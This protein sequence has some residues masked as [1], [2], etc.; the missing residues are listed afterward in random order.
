MSADHGPRPQATRGLVVLSFAGLAY[1]LGQ[2][3][4]IP[5]LG[6]LKADLGTDSS[7]VAW[8]L[9][10]YLIS[11]AV[12][13]PVFGRLGDMFGK[14]RML[15]ASLSL[16]A[17]G[18]VVS[19]LGTSLEVVVAGRVL[20]GVGGGIFPLAFGIIRDEFPPDRVGPSIGLL[21]ATLGIGGGLGLVIG[22]LVVDHASYHWIFWMSA[23]LA[24]AAGAAIATLVP[25]SPVRRP[26]RVDVRGAFVLGLGLTLPMIAIARANAWGWGSTRVVALLA[27]GI[28]ILV[29]WVALQR[30]TAEPMV[31]V[32]SLGQ[33][34]V[35]LTNLATLLVGLG[36][37]GS[38]LLIPQL[39]EAPE[40][41]GYGSAVSATTAGLVMLPGSLVILLFGPV[42]GTL[43][44]RL[45]NKVPLA[46]GAL[47][48]SLGLFLL[49]AWHGSLPVIALFNVVISIGV[50]LAYAAMPNLIVANV[51][52]HQTGEATGF[53][54]VVRSIGSSLGA[55]VSAAILAGSV[56]AT[57]GLPS[58]HGY[59]WAFVANGLVALAALAVALAIPGHARGGD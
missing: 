27:A 2:T 54:A 25:E 4:L 20:Q 43:G 7:G 58:D 19:A 11:A 42:S 33:R 45:G 55:Q 29:G 6:T 49:G 59:T 31:D 48:T 22:G 18:C 41:T 30:A 15:V 51:P 36:M 23:A 32:R 46:L 47:V 56:L 9:T 12:F 24:A 35:L 17:A 37:F 39:V 16:F 10:G 14:R 13:T 38:Y 1:A 8:L 53:N 57:T 5:A 40:S 26:G 34:P 3:T 21:S 52:R 28:A 50:G 44:A